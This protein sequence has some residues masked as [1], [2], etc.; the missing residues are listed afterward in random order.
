MRYSKTILTTVFVALV[1]S[2]TGCG[3]AFFTRP[4]EG[5]L[6][7]DNF[8]NSEQDLQRAT[9]ALY[10]QVWFDWNDGAAF[11]I[12]DARAGTMWSTDTGYQQFIDFAITSEN[13]QLIDGWRSLY[14]A[15]NQSNLVI[16]NIRNQTGGKGI[17]EEAINQAIAEARFIRG[18]AYTY[19]A[20]LWGP[21][22]VVT[23][24]PR[25]IDQSDRPRVQRDDVFQ[26]A[27][28]DFKFAAEHLPPS[29]EQP[30]RVTEWSA[31]GMLAR[32]YWAR[33]TFNDLN[34]EY[35]DQ[36]QRYARQVITQ[37]G[38]SLRENYGDLFIF[39][40]E[41]NNER[42]ESLFSLQWTYEGDTWGTQNTRQAFWAVG[43]LTGF[44]DGWGGGTGVQGWLIESFGENT[45]PDSYDFSANSSFGDEF[46]GPAGDARRSETFMMNGDQYPELMPNGYTYSLDDPA[47]A[48]SGNATSLKKYVIGP[49]SQN[50]GQVGR[51]RTGIDTY[52]LRLAEVYLTYAQ[53]FVA[54]GGGQT[55]NGEALQYYNMVRQRAGLDPDQ[56]GTLTHEEVFMEKFREL[57]FEGLNWFM[58]VRWHAYEPDAAKQF[59]RDQ[60][61][62]FTVS[63]D[64]DGEILITE[65]DDY[66]PLQISDPP[67]DPADPNTWEDNV[68]YLP[69]PE[70]DLIQNELM[71]QAPVEY[72][73]SNQ[74]AGSSG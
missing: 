74:G 49:P 70:Q 29:V 44:E 30:G 43:E 35:L 22:P 40:E 5:E 52:M 38:M 57:A 73:F 14:L 11:V 48:Y 33:A 56:D 67:V 34:Q 66:Q 17:P 25:L 41:E 63:Y 21:V 28:N 72:D 64:A 4:P 7:A 54:E 3:D 26:F 10:N 46:E 18:Y 16:Q 12:G 58:L 69:Y 9:G 50:D 1:F 62:G 68:F 2:V 19:L 51:M 53:T 23:N 59:I 71:H 65:P 6:T 15:I 37:S 60:R 42:M 45:N 24:T 32:T 13:A 8:Y 20:E 61:R 39:Q 47:G 36:S 55:S 31:K 27:I